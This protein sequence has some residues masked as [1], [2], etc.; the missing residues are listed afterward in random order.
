M[1]EADDSKTG[2]ASPVSE[3]VAR[4]SASYGAARAIDIRHARS[5]ACAHIDALER[6]CE[7]V[8]QPVLGQH[9]VWRRVGSGPV[10]VLLHGGHGSW[11]HWVRVIPLLASRFCLWMPDM[12][13]YG[14][15]TLTPDGGID[16]LVVQLRQSLDAL[17]GARTPVILAGFSFGGLVAAQLAAGR[18]RVQRLALLGPAGHGGARRQRVAPLPWRGLDPDRDPVAWADRMQ[19]NLLAQMLNSEAAVDSLAMEIHWRSCLST[20]FHSK[21]FSR[22]A[23]LDAALRACPGDVLELWGEHDVTA[24]PS[25]RAGDACRHRHIIKKSGHWLMHEAPG[26]TAIWIACGGDFC[27]DTPVH[28]C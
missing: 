27:G 16:T 26:P 11:L 10:L 25:E 17:L 7:R 14:E 3:R 5:T 15:S 6:S 20:R 1:P 4:G 24:T 23:G 12:P 19:H 13:G 28:A 21:P 9:M 22:S 2:L 18:A 8:V